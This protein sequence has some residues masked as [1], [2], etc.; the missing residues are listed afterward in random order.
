M[1]PIK[2]YVLH[3]RQDDPKKCTALK[4]ARHGYVKVIYSI[5]RVPRRAILLDPLAEK[6]LSPED[7]DRVLKWGVVA[8]DTSW[9]N[10]GNIFSKLKHIGHHRA[11]PY[12]I[13]AN[14]I[15]YGKPTILSTAEAFAATLYIV[16]LKNEAKEILSVFK[17]GY[18]GHPHLPW[19]IIGA[20]LPLHPAGRP[21]QRIPHHTSAGYWPPVARR[22]SPHHRHPMGAVSFLCRSHGF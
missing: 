16:G 3:L 9:K 4:L 13:A 6:A 1:L 21:F 14:P 22:S 17:F 12:L 18:A 7:R 10:L 20:Y 11:L 19:R 5:K 8:V 15:N 2:L